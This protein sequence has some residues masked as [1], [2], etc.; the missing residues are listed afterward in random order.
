MDD[1][2]HTSI[3]HAQLLSLG[4]QYECSVG[5]GSGHIGTTPPR[6]LIGEKAGS[7]R[8]KCERGVGIKSEKEVGIE[9]RER[10][11]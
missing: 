9:W 11:V 10:E 4:R 8:E 5:V 1:V 2:S 3:F 7:R 6:R